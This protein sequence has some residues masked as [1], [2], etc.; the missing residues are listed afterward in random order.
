MI[1]IEKIEKE[2]LRCQSCN[3]DG[4]L[5]NISIGLNLNSTSSFRLCGDCLSFFSNE[6][7]KV[8]IEKLQEQNKILKEALEYYASVKN[9]KYSTDSGLDRSEF[10]DND[11]EF[12][13]GEGH[14]YGKRAREALERV[15]E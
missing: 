3:H 15:K 10:N 2:Y 7:N 8:K 1:K 9:W 4:P 6:I 12:I 11:D 5:D 13:V 14:V